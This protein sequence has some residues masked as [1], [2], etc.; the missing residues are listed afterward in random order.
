MVDRSITVG[1]IIKT[2]T[3]TVFLAS[4]PPSLKNSQPDNKEKSVKV[5]RDIQ[6]FETQLSVETFG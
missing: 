3:Q 2:G 4:S 1:K 5:K 6:I